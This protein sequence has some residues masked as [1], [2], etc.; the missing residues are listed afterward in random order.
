VNAVVGSRSWYSNVASIML[1]VLVHVSFGWLLFSS[2]GGQSS[3][4]HVEQV[5]ASGVFILMEASEHQL[6]QGE[7]I[8]DDKQA[9]DLTS[10]LAPP[11]ETPRLPMKRVD[12]VTP[13]SIDGLK[14]PR[15]SVGRPA[16]EVLKWREAVRQAVERRWVK[17]NGV[18]VNSSCRVM[19]IQ[20]S[21]GGVLGVRVL[22]C[23][24]DD[25]IRTSLLAAI[26]HASPLPP[27]P[28]GQSVTDAEVEF[29]ILSVVQSS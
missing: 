26:F 14:M 8:A 10:S 17:P 4:I 19:L 12:N 11:V 22:Q 3:A 21:N 9:P 25:S 13:S 18:G 1:V 7:L 24:A 29:Q 23:D 6:A 20:N 15:P 16:D 28:S 2:V 5:L 27:L